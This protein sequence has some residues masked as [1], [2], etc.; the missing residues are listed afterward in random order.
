MCREQTGSV[1][2]HKET[3]ESHLRC[4]GHGF[5]GAAGGTPGQEG[6]INTFL[7]GH[8]QSYRLPFKKNPTTQKC[9][10]LPFC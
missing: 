7:I 10:T 6:V 2:T 8:S 3:H 9:H 5:V 4:C 1:C